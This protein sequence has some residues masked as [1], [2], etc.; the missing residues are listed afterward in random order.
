[1]STASYVVSLLPE[2]LT[3]VLAVLYLILLSVRVIQ[4]AYTTAR[5]KS[6]VVAIILVIAA[7]VTMSLLL[8]RPNHIGDGITL[9]SVPAIV[10]LSGVGALVTGA[11]SGLGRATA[12]VLMPYSVALIAGSCISSGWKIR[13]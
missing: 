5:A 3:G 8:S 13:R 10:R 7:T 9:E 6:V 1:M 4:A 2:R 11:A 12:S